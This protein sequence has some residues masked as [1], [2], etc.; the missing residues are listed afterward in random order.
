MASPSYF[1]LWH[2]PYF[3]YTMI[4][5]TIRILFAIKFPTGNHYCSI[6]VNKHA[7][8]YTA[9]IEHTSSVVYYLFKILRWNHYL[10]RNVFFLV[11]QS[12]FA[13][14]DHCLAIWEKG[15]V[16]I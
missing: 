3:L 6:T 8:P 9:F 14:F 5:K 1:P 13:Y 4:Q 15:V 11:I 12:T 2:T 10:R 7:F 16:N